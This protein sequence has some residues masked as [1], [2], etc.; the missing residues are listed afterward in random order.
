MEELKTGFEKYLGKTVLVDE[1][2]RTME[3]KSIGTREFTEY[4]IADEDTVIKELKA[5]AGGKVRV[6]LPTSMGTMDYRLDRLN[7]RV[8]KQNDG[9]FQITKVYFG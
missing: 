1:S 7:V 9:S 5:E 8:E 4:K 6:W 2:K 3:F